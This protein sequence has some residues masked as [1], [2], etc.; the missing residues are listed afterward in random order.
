ME[1][2]AGWGNKWGNKLG[3]GGEHLS[4]NKQLDGVGGRGENNWGK[5]T[6]G[7]GKINRLGG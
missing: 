4:E 5:Q 2:T 3:R 7:K 1:Q 6:T